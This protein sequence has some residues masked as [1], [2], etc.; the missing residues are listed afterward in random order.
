MLGRWRPI[1]LLSTIGN[2]LESILARR[3]SELAYK[4]DLLPATQMA[5]KGRSTTRTALIYLIGIIRSARKN[6]LI[7][8]MLQ[9]D[10]SGAFDHV[11]QEQLFQILQQWIIDFLCSWLS[12]RTAKVSIPG[13]T[14]ES[15]PFT[16]GIP[17]GSPLSMVLLAFS[18]AGLLDITCHEVDGVLLFKMA[19]VDDIHLIAVSTSVDLNQRVLAREY[20]RCDHWGHTSG[21][22][23]S[24]HK[25][26]LIHIGSLIERKD[27]R[28]MSDYIPQFNDPE[29]P[30][31]TLRVLGL[32][33][34]VNRR[35]NLTWDRHYEYIQAKTKILLGA[36]RRIIRPAWGLPLK[37]SRELYCTWIRPALTYGS[38]AFWTPSEDVA[39]TIRCALNHEVYDTFSDAATEYDSDMDRMDDSDS[40]FDYIPSRT[41]EPDTYVHD[42][43]TRELRGNFEARQNDFLRP[44]AGAPHGTA[45]IIVQKELYI[46]SQDCFMSRLRTTALANL[47]GTKEGKTIRDAV[48]KVEEM[49]RRNA[50]RLRTSDSDTCTTTDLLT[51]TERIALEIYEEAKDDVEYEKE[52]R[53]AE[54]RTMSPEQYEQLLKKAIRSGAKQYSH[55]KMS[56]LWK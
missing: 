5:F 11:N 35:G 23:F 45:T 40:N 10:I 17:Q 22:T 15:M 39:P 36:F 34:H 41:C 49:G 21:N 9:L 16:T 1:C 3:I 25:C 14:L 33:L 46:E 50:P 20:F 55:K 26:K 8:S 24:V 38:A 43:P 42:K 47:H 27:A 48:D 53:E 32:I 4:H 6:G 52:Q 13:Y 29:K 30:L 56:A 18:A 54:H 44:V 51:E 12:D 2:M 31:D 7:V 19:F 28:P 37:E